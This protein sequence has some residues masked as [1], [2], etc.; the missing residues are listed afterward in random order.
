[1]SLLTLGARSPEHRAE[2]ARMVDEHR[3]I[4]RSIAALVELGKG[5][6]TASDLTRQ[7]GE[8]SR[9]LLE[10]ESREVSLARALA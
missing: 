6:A 9:R 5:H 4:L 2:L 8:L 7:A 3:Q 1:M 10:H